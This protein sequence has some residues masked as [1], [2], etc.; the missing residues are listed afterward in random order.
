MLGCIAVASSLGIREAM[1][2]LLLLLLFYFLR[3]E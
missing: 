1:K 3:K 2:V